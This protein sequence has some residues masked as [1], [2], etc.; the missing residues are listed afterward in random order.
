MNGM[1]VKGCEGKV[2]KKRRDVIFIH[3]ITLTLDL[4]FRLPCFVPYG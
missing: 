1:L 2:N 4:A 3:V